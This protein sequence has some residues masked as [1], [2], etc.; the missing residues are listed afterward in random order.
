M[1]GAPGVGCS[2]HSR[3]WAGHSGRWGNFTKRAGLPTMT[4]ERRTDATGSGSPGHEHARNA[5]GALPASQDRSHG[6]DL[7]AMPPGA[8]PDSRHGQTTTATKAKQHANKTYYSIQRQRRQR[9]LFTV[10]CQS[11]GPGWHRGRTLR[12]AAM[13][14]AQAL[15]LGGGGTGNDSARSHKRDRSKGR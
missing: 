5:T 2:Y 15:R 7:R 4:G 6:P 14:S 12:R 1:S 10:H 8:G 3:T 13:L 9:K 11:Q